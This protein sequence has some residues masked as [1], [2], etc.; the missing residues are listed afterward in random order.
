MVA[1]IM[2]TNQNPQILKTDLIF[3]SAFSTCK[4]NIYEI[5]VY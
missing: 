5:F 3:L 1:S 4:P 2:G